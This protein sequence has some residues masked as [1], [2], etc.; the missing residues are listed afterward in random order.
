MNEDFVEWLKENRFDCEHNYIYTIEEW[1]FEDNYC[2]DGENLKV[3]ALGDWA[4]KEV[5]G[6]F[7]TNNLGYELESFKEPYKFY[8]KI[9]VAC[10][11]EKEVEKRLK[12]AGK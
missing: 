2:E 3:S 4:W 10:L 9:A 12:Q 1:D 5:E 7:L 8:L 6:F 11:G